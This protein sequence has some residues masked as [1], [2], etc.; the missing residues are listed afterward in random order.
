M[1]L[2]SVG[3]LA[4]R[5]AAAAAV[6][7]MFLFP[8]SFLHAF[9]WPQPTNTESD[10]VTFCQQCTPHALQ[11]Q[12]LARVPAARNRS[13]TAWFGMKMKHNRNNKQQTIHHAP[14]L[15]QWRFLEKR[16]R[17]HKTT[18][19]HKHTCG[20]GVRVR[21]GERSDATKNIDRTGRFH[22]PSFG[23]ISHG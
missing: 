12:T 7:F 4:V 13:R 8:Y 20:N 14:A 6:F 17:K 1:H 15:R 21:V 23:I 2:R 18:H 9:P 10:S 11:P 5:A 19:T 3:L 22:N 16:E